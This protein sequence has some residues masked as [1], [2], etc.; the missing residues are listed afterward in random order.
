MELKMSDVKPEDFISPEEQDG[1]N[2]LDHYEQWCKTNK[3][4]VKYLYNELSAEDA[5]IVNDVLAKS[6]YYRE[7]FQ[8]MEGNPH[9]TKYNSEEFRIK[10]EGAYKRFLRNENYKKLTDSNPIEQMDKVTLDDFPSLAEQKGWKWDRHFEQWRKTNKILV[11]YLFNELS[12]DDR[13]T[14]KQV[15]DDSSYYRV[16]INQLLEHPDRLKYNS[17]VFSKVME[18]SH[19]LVF[20]KIYQKLDML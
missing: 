4:L 2:W 18:Q 1:W 15:L 20:G 13:Q 6:P 3:V 16:R 9:R 12:A 19:K 5:G 14:V 17:E 10:M 11:K 8:L 7:L